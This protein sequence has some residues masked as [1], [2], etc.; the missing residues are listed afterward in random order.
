M[1]LARIGGDRAAAPVLPSVRQAHRHVEVGAGAD[2]RQ[3]AAVWGAQL[4]G[5]HPRGELP[6]DG[7]LQG[8]WTLAEDRQV[9]HP[10][11][12]GQLG[13]QGLDLGPQRYDGA[14][15]LGRGEARGDVLRAVPVEGGDLDQHQPLD[16]G[17]VVRQINLPQQ[18]GIG[19]PGV[20]GAQVPDAAGWGSPW[21]LRRS[22]TEN[23][24]KPIFVYW[25][26]RFWGGQLG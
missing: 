1:A 26:Q 16:P 12:S 25:V 7:D 3:V 9:C 20:D 21:G 10:W 22:G 14:R 24:F 5:T 4:I 18:R 11:A 15:D 6:D 8:E 2:R 19:G 13:A 23:R 17:R